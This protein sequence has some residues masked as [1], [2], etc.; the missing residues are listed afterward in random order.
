MTEHN[1]PDIMNKRAVILGL[2]GSGKTVLSGALLDT[3]KAHLVYDVHHEYK[4]KYNTYLA[5]HKRVDPR[6]KNDP[7]IAELN[8]V[9]NQ[10]VLESGMVRLFALDEANRFCPNHYP[11][12]ASI[13]VLNDDN[14]H[15]RIAFITIARRPSQLNTDLT[16]LAHYMFIF[17]L[18]GRNDYKFLEDTVVGLGDAVRELKEFYFIIVDPFRKFIVHPPIDIDKK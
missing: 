1:L 9:V 10:L 12:P 5:E 16:E 13:L 7:G 6:K 11:L 15:D 14:R 18:T 17:S 4:G 8:N 2:Q 3:E